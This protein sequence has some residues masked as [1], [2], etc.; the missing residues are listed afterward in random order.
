MIYGVWC[1]EVIHKTSK[2]T[3]RQRRKIKELTGKDIPPG[4]D[5][6]GADRIIT[7]AV[8]G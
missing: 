3:T 2:P 1:K 5:R 7:E 6:E 4:T 8:G